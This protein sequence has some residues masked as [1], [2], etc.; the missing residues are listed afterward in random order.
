M[1]SVLQDG[2]QIIGR[3][4]L[5]LLLPYSHMTELLNPGCA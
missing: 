4:L 1:G 5:E 2:D 3:S